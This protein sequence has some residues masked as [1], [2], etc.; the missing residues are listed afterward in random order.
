MTITET[1]AACHGRQR[2][3]TVTRVQRIHYGYRVRMEC[4]HGH[5]MVKWMKDRP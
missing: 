4:K 3:F 1:C 2:D 5:R